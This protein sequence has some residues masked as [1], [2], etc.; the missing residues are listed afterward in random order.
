MTSS[1]A[2]PFLAARDLLIRHR[3]DYSAACREFQWPKLD[4]FNWAL[5]YFDDMARGNER[6]ALWLTDEDAG[7]S[8]LSFAQLSERSSRV[9]NALRGLGVRRGDRILLMLGNVIP[10]WECMLAAMKLGAVIVPATMLL[11]RNDLADRFA[12]GRVRHVIAAAD[13]APKFE[14]LP[15]D[16]TRMAV[17]G[18]APAWVPYES[19]YDAPPQ[20]MPDGETRADDPFLLYFTSGT[21]ATPKLVLHSHQSYPVGHLSTMYWLGLRPGDVHL[22]ISSPGWAK[23]AW[24]CFFA[25]W[26]AG[27]TVFMVNQRRFDARILLETIARCGVTTFCAPP[28]V[29]RM[30]IQED[31]AAW[32][33]RLHELISAGEPLNPEVIERV[34][35]AW[36]LTIR[37]GY[38]Q[39][40]TTALVGNTPGQRLKAGSMGRPLPGYRVALL[41]H[42]GRMQKEGEICLTLSPRPTG[43]MQ[44]Y[45]GDNGEVIAIDDAVYRTGDVAS[46]DDDGYLTYVGR[47]D[48]VFK[49]SDYRIS[50]F[51]LESVLIEHPAVAE[52]AVV[53]SPDPMRLAVPK[54]FLALASG[55]AADRA[56]ALSIFRHCRVALAPFKRVRRLEFADL[57]KTISG[58]I[59][60]VELRRAEADQR[61]ADQR[62]SLEFWEEDFSETELHLQRESI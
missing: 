21:T 39:T 57:P 54:A 16:Y 37:D 61:G 4:R 20:F 58:K 27:A 24:S 60:R 6:P 46:V 30:L 53:P 10:L 41:D 25:P 28:T 1:N 35:A 45:Q 13:I 51:E 32:P 40:E 33:V 62:A 59:R 29:W 36:D 38:G 3:D 12:R 47:A 19:T 56:T 42:A 26:N 55:Y 17:G 7:E 49:S 5:D 14:E 18:A 23:H 52:A 11:T 48:D 34:K 43:L 50:P 15:G 44:G 31:L 9:A 2:A 22:N 8:K